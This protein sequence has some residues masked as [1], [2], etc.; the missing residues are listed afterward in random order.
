MAAKGD[1]ND[2]KDV[3]QCIQYYFQFHDEISKDQKFSKEELSIFLNETTDGKLISPYAVIK[4]AHSKA[5]M[6]IDP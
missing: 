2:P 5:S 4:Y 6:G 1:K 3:F